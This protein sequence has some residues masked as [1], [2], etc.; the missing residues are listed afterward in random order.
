MSIIK[1]INGRFY[2]LH[3]PVGLE[4]KTKL[5]LVLVFHGGGSDPVAVEWESRFSECADKYGFVVAYLAG[6]NNRFF[7]KDRF[8]YWNDGR[9]FSDGSYSKSDDVGYTRKV[10][11]HISKTISIDP[12]RVYGAGYSNG[13]QFCIRL[14]QQ[15]SDLI[16]SVACLCSWRSPD[17][18]FP[19]PPR[20]VSI[21]LMA[22]ENDPINPI[23]GGKPT[24]EGFKMNLKPF[25]EVTVDW[26]TFNEYID[27]EIVT[28]SVINTGGHTWPGGR[29]ESRM[30][31]PVD[32][33]FWCAEEMWKFFEKT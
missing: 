18:I 4:K 24:L 19:N 30:L 26:L 33:S 13:A 27:R 32:N 16:K 29:S 7:I 31:G 6:T 21:C 10:V 11:K 1:R 14:A 22:G 2:R 12:T 25:S 17:D 15:A 23:G 9:P 5:P 20:Q 3:I 8:L 28:A